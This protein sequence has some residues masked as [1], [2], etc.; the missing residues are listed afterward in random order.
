MIFRNQKPYDERAKERREEGKTK[1]SPVAQYERTGLTYTQ[2]AKQRRAEEQGKAE[3]EK[4]RKTQEATQR[5]VEIEAT[6][7]RLRRPANVW[8]DLIAQWQGRG[9]DPAVRAKLREYKRREKEE[10]KKIDA[11]MAERERRHRIETDPKVKDALAHCALASQFA[12]ESERE[13]WAIAKGLAEGGA[14]DKYW[15]LSK[16]LTEHAKDREQA[17]LNGEADRLGKLQADFN[18]SETRLNATL[19]CARQ[20]LKA[21]GVTEPVVIEP[22]V[23]EPVVTE[24]VVIEPVVIEPVVT[25]PAVTEAPA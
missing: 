17:R 23:I 9:Y 5:Q 25:E 14:I 1:K 12:T 22:V 16:T 2:R 10:D 21:S 4:A 8:T 15:A 20:A 13:Q 6:P 7:A 11:E 18:E 24:P 3:A 19:A